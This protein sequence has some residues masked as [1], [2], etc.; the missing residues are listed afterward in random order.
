M[1]IYIHQLF[2]SVF[3]GISQKLIMAYLV[4]PTIDE[5]LEAV[6]EYNVEDAIEEP[7]PIVDT[8]ENYP[9]LSV[10][11]IEFLNADALQPTTV[12][13]TTP[14]TNDSILDAPITEISERVGVR[15]KFIDRHEDLEQNVSV[16]EDPFIYP[17]KADMTVTDRQ[18]FTRSWGFN[19]PNDM[20]ASVPRPFIYP[21]NGWM[22]AITA[23]SEENN[24]T[25]LTWHNPRVVVENDVVVFNGY[26]VTHPDGESVMD[27]ENIKVFRNDVFLYNDIDDEY[28]PYTFRWLGGSIRHTPFYANVLGIIRSIPADVIFRLD[29]RA[30]VHFFSNPTY[31]QE[32]GEYATYMSKYEEVAINGLSQALTKAEYV[33]AL[34]KPQEFIGMSVDEKLAMFF[35]ISFNDHINNR[36]SRVFAGSDSMDVAIIYDYVRLYYKEYTTVNGY[37]VRPKPMYA[38]RFFCPTAKFGCVYECLKHIGIIRGDDDMRRL[39]RAI[40]GLNFSSV[41]ITKMKKI[42]ELLSVERNA[43]IMLYKLTENGMNNGTRYGDNK[44]PRYRLLQYHGHMMV[45]K[46]DKYSDITANMFTVSEHGSPNTVDVQTIEQ[47]FNEIVASKKV[48]DHRSRGEFKFPNV[49]LWDTETFDARDAGFEVYQLSVLPMNK[50]YEKNPNARYSNITGTYW[51]MPVTCDVSHPKA[52]SIKRDNGTVDTYIRT[53]RV[54]EG[55]FAAVRDDKTGEYWRITTELTA[56]GPYRLAAL[57]NPDTWDEKNINAPLEEI[58]NTS[59]DESP[60]MTALGKSFY[61]QKDRRDTVITRFCAML[62]KICASKEREYS[63]KTLAILAE[64]GV[65]RANQSLIANYKELYNNIYNA[66]MQNDPDKYQFWAHNSAKFDSIMFLR[67]INAR[68]NVTSVLHSHGIISMTYRNT[69]QFLDSMKFSGPDGGLAAWCKAMAVPQFLSKM[70]MPYAFASRDTLHYKGPVPSEAYW[71]KKLIPSS[72]LWSNGTLDNGEPQFDMRWFTTKYAMFDVVSLGVCLYRFSYTM[73]QATKQCNVAPD[74]SLAQVNDSSGLIM[75]DFVT[76][77]SLAESILYEYINAGYGS[78][79]TEV[80]N[81][82]HKKGIVRDGHRGR[83]T[84]AFKARFDIDPSKDED[85]ARVKKAFP[86][87]KL[88]GRYATMF[89]DMRPSMTTNSRR[90]KH[91]VDDAPDDVKRQCPSYNDVVYAC[92]NAY[93][94]RHIRLAMRG[95]RSVPNKASFKTSSDWIGPDGQRDY[96]KLTDYLMVLD[97]TSLYPSAMIAFEYPT[98]KPSFITEDKFDERVRRFNDGQQMPLCSIVDCEIT[99]TKKDIAFPIVSVKSMGRALYT[100]EDKRVQMTN[101]D[102]E[103][104]IKY[105]YVR[106]TKIHSIYEWPGRRDV[107]SRVVNRFFAMRLAAKQAGNK[108][109]DTICKLIMN[110]FY[111]VTVKELVDTVTDIVEDN[112]TFE[113]KLLRYNVRE[114]NDFGERMKIERVVP[115]DQLKAKTP[116]QLGIFVLAFSKRLMN[117]CVDEFDG[118]GLRARERYERG[119]T[120]YEAF[121]E[122]MWDRA[123][124]YTDTDSLYIRVQYYNELIGKCNPWGKEWLF[125]YFDRTK[126]DAVDTAAMNAITDPVERFDYYPINAGVKLNGQL[127]QFHDDANDDLYK[128]KVYEAYFVAPK[129]K[130]IRY[131]GIDPKSSPNAFKYVD[132]S[133]GTFKGVQGKRDVVLGVIDRRAGCKIE[134]VPANGPTE[135]VSERGLITRRIMDNVTQMSVQYHDTH[136][137]GR[138]S[139]HRAVKSTPFTLEQFAALNADKALILQTQQFE[140]S[141]RLDYSIHNPYKIKVVNANA[142]AGKQKINGRF[143]CRDYVSQR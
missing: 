68:G 27:I 94:D 81:E 52:L 56:E 125:P 23:A 86:R 66:V 139:E 108:L 28:V 114:Y 83:R 46:G 134:V 8:E 80:F 43:H 97:A 112:E 24:S 29:A 50:L 36:Y 17:Y 31:V 18:F 96:D 128:P 92:E 75:Y 64:Y 62:D 37:Y 4:R 44:A 22:F 142:Y 98:G 99:H 47:K 138:V 6:R 89:F 135:I 11:E 78:N 100:F 131:I 14:G 90:D 103:D 127:T 130:S 1:Y 40:P 109:M 79:P 67:E 122:E 59:C 10:D 32:N 74:G 61:A 25:M 30:R 7:Q 82:R 123:P 129:C 117:M 84:R 91:T 34:I 111:G 70:T 20:M 41:G 54:K 9:I 119:E 42:M 76:L 133:K 57:F 49:Y 106:V 104:A 102:L 12:N 101:V 93:I 107:F 65:T 63:N 69:I 19:F 115:M 15:T 35:M 116:S 141:S 51:S 110:I 143:M 72:Q 16:A 71:E 5:L 126:F 33:D 48:L 88:D 120:T 60:K 13:V 140:R 124:F 2:S 113:E 38:D 53:E 137:K 118:F 45:I 85:V 21:E 58:V 121:V 55:D 26:N 87:A 39:A 95:G 132:G 73:F 77:A 3:T 136:N 105:N